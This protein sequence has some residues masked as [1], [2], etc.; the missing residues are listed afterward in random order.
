MKTAYTLRMNWSNNL[1]KNMDRRTIVPILSNFRHFSMLLQFIL[2]NMKILLASLIR[3]MGE[4]IESKKTDTVAMERKNSAW[5]T[6][7]THYNSQPES[8]TI[9]TA[10]Q[11]KKL[12][13]NIKQRWDF[14]AV[15]IDQSATKANSAAEDIHNNDAAVVAVVQLPQEQWMKICLSEK[16]APVEIL[17]KPP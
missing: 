1:S 17:V 14:T 10:Q 7:T 3:D 4:A 8:T 9:R 15:F 11:L 6:I 13:A 12:W 2:K 16:S 5:E